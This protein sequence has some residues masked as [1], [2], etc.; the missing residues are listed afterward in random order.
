MDDLHRAAGGISRT[1]RPDLMNYVSFGN[2][3]PH[4]HWHLVPRY[5]NDPRWGMP[6][7]TSDPGDM[8]VTRLSDKEYRSLIQD[9]NRQFG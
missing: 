5:R 7:Y 8:R 2:V 9:L 6:I 1:C 3:V 4:L